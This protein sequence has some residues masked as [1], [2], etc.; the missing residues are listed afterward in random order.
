MCMYIPTIP[1]IREREREGGG[2]GKKEGKED[3]HS[4]KHYFS[5]DEW[6]MHNIQS[7]VVQCMWSKHVWL[8][9]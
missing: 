2:R 9:G 7:Y 1:L 3:R 6:L 8:L 5:H 4:K